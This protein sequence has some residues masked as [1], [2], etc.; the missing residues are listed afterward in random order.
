MQI[1]SRALHDNSTQRSLLP[2]NTLSVGGVASSKRYRTLPLPFPSH[3]RVHS[4]PA[5]ENTIKSCPPMP[6]VAPSP[7]MCPLFPLMS[8]AQIPIQKKTRDALA[9]TEKINGRLNFKAEAPAGEGTCLNRPSKPARS[10][11]T[12]E[13]GGTWQKCLGIQPRHVRICVCS[14]RCFFFALCSMFSL[15]LVLVPIRGFK[16]WGSYW[17]FWSVSII[18]HFVW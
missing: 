5:Q 17:K 8:K 11:P 12:G 2:Q 15:P 4:P 16:I 3:P 9:I 13:G 7:V 14:K 18:W 6:H 1:P 10:I